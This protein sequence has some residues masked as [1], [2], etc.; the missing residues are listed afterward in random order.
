MFE[1]QIYGTMMIYPPDNSSPLIPLRDE[2]VLEGNFILQTLDVDH[3]E[4][5]SS[6]LSLV[7]YSFKMHSFN[8]WAHVT[9][10]MRFSKH[11]VS[12]CNNGCHLIIQHLLGICKKHAQLQM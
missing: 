5:Y 7:F 11:L 3:N 1:P 2:G 6:M 10:Q 12:R 4:N 8:W 9:H